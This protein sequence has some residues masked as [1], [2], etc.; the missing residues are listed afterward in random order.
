MLDGRAK[1]SPTLAFVL[2]N[3]MRT[4]QLTWPQSVTTFGVSEIHYRLL[5]SVVL[6]LFAPTHPCGQKEANSSNGYWWNALSVIKWMRS[7]F[8]LQPNS[9]SP[10]K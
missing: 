10:L 3:T 7:V 1:V 6:F 5:L 8:S 9:T 2:R 4:L